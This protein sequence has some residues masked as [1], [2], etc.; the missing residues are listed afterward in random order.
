[1]L[2]RS[3]LGWAWLFLAGAAWL[4][5]PFSSAGNPA[6]EHAKLALISEQAAILPDQ[7]LWMGVQFD[8]EEGWHTYWINPGDSGEPP[9]IEWEL[10]PGFQAGPIQWP[11]PARLSTPPLADYGYEHQVLLMVAV[12]PAP[13]LQEGTSQRIA[14]R[15]R[16]LICREVCIPGQKRLELTL[17]VRK[18]AVASSTAP[19]FELARERLPRPAPKGWKMSAASVGDEFQLN[20]RIGTLTATPQFFPLEVEQ[21]ENAAFEAIT[22][23][24]GG[25]RLHLKKSNHLLKPIPRLKGVIVVG[26]GNAYLVDVPVLPPSRRAQTQSMKN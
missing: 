5:L 21:I 4:I 22:T 8:L 2:G 11:Y 10:P 20:L 19:G 15:V 16:Y 26:S 7:Q 14:A 18:D 25:I 3:I 17:P 24:P 13:G 12:R 6:E 9:R 23:I 1:M